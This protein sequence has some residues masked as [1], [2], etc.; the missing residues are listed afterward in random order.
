VTSADTFLTTRDASVADLAMLLR[1]HHAASS[2]S[3][4]RHGTSASGR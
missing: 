1:T 2:T 4:P 3:S